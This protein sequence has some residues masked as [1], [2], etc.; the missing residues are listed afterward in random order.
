MQHIL[1]DT[2]ISG[3]DLIYTVR[4]NVDLFCMQDFVITL[5]YGIMPSLDYS[6]DNTSL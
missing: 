2:P 3:G 4:S 1:G 5:A 6:N